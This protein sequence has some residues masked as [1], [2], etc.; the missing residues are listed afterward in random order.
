LEAIAKVIYPLKFY[1]GLSVCPDTVPPIAKTGCKIFC[2]KL[3][4]SLHN[5][6]TV[7]T[8]YAYANIID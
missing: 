6:V 2:L 1:S 4:K 8:D 5:F 3:A 7:F